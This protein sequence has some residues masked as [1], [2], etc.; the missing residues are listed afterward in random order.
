MMTRSRLHR[1][2]EGWAAARIT[3]LA[4]TVTVGACS[5]APTPG[6]EEGTPATLSP[7]PAGYA[8]RLDRQNRDRADFV[9][10]ASGDGG[11]LLVR[12]GPAGILYRP[13]RTV[14]A[15]DYTLRGRFTEIDPPLG[16]REG[17]GLFIGGDRLDGDAQRY[18]YFLVRGD[19][20][21]LIKERNGPLTR[22]LSNGWQPSEAVRVPSAATGA[23]TNEL[24]ISVDGGRIS[25]ACNGEP[26][27]ELSLDDL[28]A[29][30]VVGVRVNHNLQVRIADLRVEP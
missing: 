23:V 22:E 1:L 4:A 12:T 15:G 17:F 6:P 5:G 30:G 10:S 20:R 19:G 21:Y 25:F 2:A 3:L 16:H 28:T 7:L 11:D 29:E 27:A 14:D 13:A 26:V 9:V 8:L 18:I 24:S